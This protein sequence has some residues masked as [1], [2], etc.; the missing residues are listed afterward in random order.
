[1]LI[2]IQQLLDAGEKAWMLPLMKSSFVLA[3]ERPLTAWER[4][5]FCIALCSV[6]S[7]RHGFDGVFGLKVRCEFYPENVWLEAGGLG[8]HRLSLDGKYQQA[9]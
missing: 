1:M 7:S 5:L 6:A 3:G 9:G 4:K 2:F 8:L